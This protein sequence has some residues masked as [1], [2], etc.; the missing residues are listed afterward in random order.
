MSNQVLKI[1]HVKGLVTHADPQDIPVDAVSR[2]AN[3]RPVNG[4]LVR[5]FGYGQNFSR[6]R[7]AVLRQEG[8]SVYWDD[9]KVWDDGDYWLDNTD[10]DESLGDP[11]DHVIVFENRNLGYCPYATGEG[12]VIIAYLVD[13]DTGLVTL[14]YWDGDSWE[15]LASTG[16]MVNALGSYYHHKG[17]NPVIL[18]NEILRILPGATGKINGNNAEGIWIGYIDRDI[19][20]EHYTAGT[21]EEVSEETAD[22]VKGFYNYSNSVPAP[23]ISA[24]GLDPVLTDEPTG[25]SLN[26]D[27]NELVYFYRLSYVY[28]GVNESALSETLSKS[29]KQNTF[30]KMALTFTKAEHNKRIT[31]VKIYRSSYADAGFQQIHTL[32]LTRK[33]DKLKSVDGMASGLSRFYIPGLAYYNFDNTESYRIGVRVP[34]DTGAFTYNA[35]SPPSGTGN[36]IFVTSSTLSG[37]YW[38]YEWILE[39]YDASWVPIDSGTSGVFAGTHT[40]ISTEVD[41]G[42]ENQAGGILYWPSIAYEIKESVNR[43]IRIYIAIHI[44]IPTRP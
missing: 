41:L 3:L 29:F 6:D 24:S 34:G 11:F 5:T 30:L 35:I 17:N 44:P 14:K 22:Y 25:G 36:V 19:F 18:H 40:F 37:D 16:L 9:S 15:L 2:L 33:T 20:D 13:T 4:K 32:D 43:A 39:Y 31:A 21:S 23:D 38:D 8:K 1:T 28:D 27:G 42:N 10:I 7:L 26:P 12:Y